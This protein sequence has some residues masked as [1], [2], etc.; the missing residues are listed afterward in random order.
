MKTNTKISVVITFELFFLALKI[1]LTNTIN[2]S[3]KK[4]KEA[5]YY[6]YIIIKLRPRVCKLERYQFA[7]ILQ[8]VSA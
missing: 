7:I 5:Y 3:Q 2:L 8:F 6:K 1:L 4:R